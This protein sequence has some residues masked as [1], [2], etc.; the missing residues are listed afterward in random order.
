MK[1][2]TL[3]GI[4]ENGQIRLAGDVRLPEKT[5]VYVVIPGVEVLSVGYIG[6]PRLVHPEQAADFKKEVVEEN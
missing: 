5:T 1:V 3:P 4:V 2:T 6:S